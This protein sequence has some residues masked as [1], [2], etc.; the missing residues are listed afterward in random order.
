[1]LLREVNVQCRLL[2]L[3]KKRVRTASKRTVRN[4]EWKEKL[5]GSIKS[6]EKVVEEGNATEAENQLQQTIKVI[7]KA[8]G[9]G[10]IHKNNAARKKSRLTKM[11]NKIA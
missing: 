2:N 11:L 9:K 3:Q 6:F 1:M 5:K 4:R 10:I 7:D 8:A